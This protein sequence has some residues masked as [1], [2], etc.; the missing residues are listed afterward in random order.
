MATRA[1]TASNYLP[2]AWLAWLLPFS[3]TF[4]K[5]SGTG[6]RTR[7]IAKRL[8][9][10]Y[11]NSFPNSVSIIHTLSSSI[12]SSLSFLSMMFSYCLPQNTRGTVRCCFTVP[13]LSS[14]PLAVRVGSTAIGTLYVVIWRISL[15]EQTG[16]APKTSDVP[17]IVQLVP[18]GQQTC[19]G[20]L[21]SNKLTC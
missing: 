5:I 19:P 14:S 15:I 20:I 6:D 4:C 21:Q 2:Y 3:S 12:L 16:S 1:S 7:Y 13:Y 10:F 8:Y 17:L 9:N 11:F 18:Y